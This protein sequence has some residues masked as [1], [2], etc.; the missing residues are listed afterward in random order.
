MPKEIN[1]SIFKAYDVRGLYPKEINENAV[2]NIGRALVAHTGAEKVVVGFD[3]RGTSLKIQESL[4][5]GITDQGADVFKIG[6]SS[7]P[8]LYF[9]SWKLE[10]IDAAI[11]ITASHNP[12]EYN[13]LKLCLRN[14]VPIGE[15]S[16]MEKIKE[17]AIK[18]HFLDREEKGNVEENFDLK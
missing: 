10:D 12:A 4:V 7:T 11:M 16:G 8:M 1:P 17:L 15:G 2:Y 5:K 13:G 18:D 3:M 14:A 9:A 6:L